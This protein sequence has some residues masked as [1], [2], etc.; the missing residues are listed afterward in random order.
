MVDF[1]HHFYLIR[2]HDLQFISTVIF[3]QRHERA[4]RGDAV[5]ALENLGVVERTVHLDVHV[6]GLG[7]VAPA[8]LHHADTD[9]RIADGKLPCKCK[10]AS[11]A[12]LEGGDNSEN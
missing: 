8:V 9:T 2:I 6:I 5:L 12:D 1:S 4:R 7:V 3:L 10:I 11:K